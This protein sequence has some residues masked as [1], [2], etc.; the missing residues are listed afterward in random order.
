MPVLLIDPQAD[1]LQLVPET[2]QDTIA[3]EVPVSEAV[4]W[5]V[6]PEVTIALVGVTVTATIGT[7][8]T[9]AEA[10]LVGSATLLAITLMVAGEGA[11]A[12]AE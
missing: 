5:S 7:I 3:F 1:P 4:N 8:V 2:V 10:D 12:G 9:F 11:T 6:D